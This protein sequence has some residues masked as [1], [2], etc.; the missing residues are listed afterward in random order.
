MTI[1]SGG[2]VIE[3]GDEDKPDVILDYDMNG[4]MVGMESSMPASARKSRVR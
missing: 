4:N 3:E 2:A 1:F